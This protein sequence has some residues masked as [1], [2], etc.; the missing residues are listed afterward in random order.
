MSDEGVE[1]DAADSEDVRHIDDGD[2][3][4]ADMYVHHTGGHLLL[5]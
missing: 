3:A 5:M 4:S 1:I 2:N